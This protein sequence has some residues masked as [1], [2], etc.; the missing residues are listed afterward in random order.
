MTQSLSGAQSHDLTPDVAFA[1]ETLVSVVERKSGEFKASILLLSDDGRHLLDAA[2]PSLPRA[3][4]DA[5]HGLAIGPSVGSC[6]T[7]AYTNQRVIVSDIRKD[8]RWEAFRELAAAHDLAACW[9]QPI[10]GANGRV[11]GTFAMYYPEPR[12]PNIEEL[13][14]IDAAAA[15]AATIIEHA[16]TGATRTELVAGL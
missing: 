4:R 16:R 7:A 12:D 8:P 15:R 10:R 3:Y 5:I 6:G 2:A 11:L 14:I 1:L 9:S 13:H